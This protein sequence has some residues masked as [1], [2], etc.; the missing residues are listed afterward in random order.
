MRKISLLIVAVVLLITSS[1][2]S[3]LA[4]SNSISITPSGIVQ[5]YSVAA[6]RQDKSKI[7]ITETK[8]K[9][10]KASLKI[11]DNI[12]SGTITANS[13]NYN[14]EGQKAEQAEFKQPRFEGKVLNHENLH[15]EAFLLDNN[16]AVVNIFGL[17][18]EG[19]RID[20]FTV[21]L[22]GSKP[23]VTKKEIQDPISDVSTLADSSNFDYFGGVYAWGIDMEAQGYR[24]QTGSTPYIVRVWTDPNAP[25]TDSQQSSITRINVYKAYIKKSASSGSSFQPVNPSADG[26][27]S[28]TVRFTVAGKTIS[29]P[30]ST[31][32]TQITPDGFGNPHEVTY[33]WALKDAYAYQEGNDSE[34]ILAEHVYWLGNASKNQYGYY[35]SSV[36]GR[37]WYDVVGNYRE[38]FDYG[39][40]MNIWYN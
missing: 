3:A 28:F 40:S 23:K 7:S 35:E 30:V 13:T 27:T 16:N 20:P 26:S 19:D 24:Y 14:L 10:A 2:T 15:F 8:G 34:G 21:R 9:V 32:S 33:T 39:T 12:I 25:K 1:T 6:D 22:D 31:S 18:E 38:Y 11:T 36:N 4:K 5:S 37:L 29:I 17:S